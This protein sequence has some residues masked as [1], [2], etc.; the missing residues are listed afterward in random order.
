MS[1]VM[2]Y[3]SFFVADTGMNREIKQQRLLGMRDRMSL[4]KL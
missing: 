3:C 4:V 2:T 1:V